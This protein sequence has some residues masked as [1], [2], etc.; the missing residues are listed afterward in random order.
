MP[1]QISKS[2]IYQA[3][4]HVNHPEI[5]NRNLVD[6]RVISEVHVKDSNVHV[7]LALP[8]LQSPIKGELIEAVKQAVSEI[9]DNLNV[10]ISV[11]EMNPEQRSAFLAIAREEHSSPKPSTHVKKVI[12]VL[13]GKGGVGK[14]SV[15]GLL[16]SSLRRAGYQ[17]GIL[18][19]D[20]TGPSI[21]KIFGVSK[22]PEVSPEGILPV[23]SFRGIKIMSINLLLPDKDQPVVWRGPLIGGAIT[24][25]W[26]EIAWGNLDYLIIDLPPGTSDAALTVMQSLPLN[27]VLLV[28]SPQDLAGMVVRKASFMALR[29]GIPI[30]GLVENMSYIICPKC[31]NRI[32]LFGNSRAD[33]TARKIGT[34][35]LGHLAL[36]SALSVFCDS[37][38]IEE[39]YSEAFE[40]ITTTVVQRLENMQMIP[41]VDVSLSN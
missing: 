13:S 31:S 4:S 15:A 40:V 34:E 22:S 17:V 7:T 41:T 3:L 35:L 10:D 18:D 14:S 36:D 5:T 29:L 30:I 2:D 25:F 37:G 20:I 16:A 32:N 26:T 38:E 19:A 27:G 12:A 8:N 6:L 9:T 23:R 21:P 1:K 24:Q 11:T 39:Y 28:T 33:E